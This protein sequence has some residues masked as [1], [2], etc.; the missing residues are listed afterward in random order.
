MSSILNDY[1]LDT[2]CFLSEHAAL[3]ALSMDSLSQ[4]DKP[5]SYVVSYF[6][7]NGAIREVGTYGWPI[8][9]MAMSTTAIPKFGLALGAEGELLSIDR[10]GARDV[11]AA[12]SPN[13]AHLRGPMR[14]VRCIDGQMIVVGMNRQAYVI[15][16]DGLWEDI[17]PAPA[18]G[19]VSGFEAIAG[20]AREDIVC[21][22]WRGE[23]WC[24]TAGAWR[25]LPS[26]T[27]TLITDLAVSEDG[28]YY[29]CGLNGLVLTGRGD[30]WR[31]LDQGRFDLNLYSVAVAGEHVYPSSLYGVYEL[32]DDL[33]YRVAI[34]PPPGTAHVV[35]AIGSGVALLGAKDLYLMS[36]G[37][38]RRLE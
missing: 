30:Q 7:D 3:L 26:P 19:P 1:S 22:G 37:R 12:N 33:L 35:Q 13:N 10:S 32:R 5:H 2:G 6:V 29:A 4:Q 36:D 18:V 28:T 38:W 25:Q 15:H 11:S 16:Q 9:S 34:A 17:S 31:V 27:N 20:L 21:A 24:R 14:K 23:I 8:V